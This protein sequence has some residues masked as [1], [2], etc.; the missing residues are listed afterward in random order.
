M[1]MA[2]VYQH[3]R[4]S[5]RSLVEPSL[6][7]NGP[8]N[9]MTRICRR[10]CSRRVSRGRSPPIFVTCRC[11]I[12]A[13]VAS[14]KSYNH[15]EGRLKRYIFA[16]PSAP[17]N[18]DP[19]LARTR[20]ESSEETARMQIH[21]REQLRWIAVEGEL[22]HVFIPGAERGPTHGYQPRVREVCAL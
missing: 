2:E 5:I 1:R 3:A 15:A 21:K 20:Q 18:R 6:L 7:A 16:Q 9:R 17:R 22:V 12:P 11:L 4:P 8:S 14:D 10:D 13:K 19:S